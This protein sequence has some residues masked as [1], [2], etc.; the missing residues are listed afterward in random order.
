MTAT[1]TLCGEI[2]TAVPDVR[3]SL[4]TLK[5]FG[6]K[7][8]EHMKLKHVEEFKAMLHSM[9]EAGIAAQGLILFSRLKSDDVGFLSQT[10]EMREVVDKSC[11]QKEPVSVIV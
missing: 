6:G 11:A 8:G 9:G 7:V 2:L 1:C 10:S 4:H 5:D 3:G